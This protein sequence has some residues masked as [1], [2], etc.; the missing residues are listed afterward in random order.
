MELANRRSNRIAIDALKIAPDDT[1][2]ELGF[3]P[4]RAV[5]A[6]AALAPQGCVLGIDHSATMLARASR[7][8]RRAI[9][10]KR[11][12]LLRGRFDALPWRADSVDRILAVHVIYFAG[13]A[14]IRE[15]R[16]VLRP[17]GSI[18]IL[19]T[20]KSAMARWRFVQFS[21][22]SIF[23]MDDLAAL[24][25]RGGFATR[26]FVISR[27]KLSFGVPGLLAMAT[28]LANEEVAAPDATRRGAFRAQ[29]R[30]MI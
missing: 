21:T 28:K 17:G 16:R 25:L 29:S 22:H 7:S 9:R 5:R 12:Y 1:I 14:E 18:V 2:L 3:G 4:G 8:N 19:A 11:V 20:D 10:E 26:E 27:I 30:S 13:A 6:L 15:A 24:L 23:D